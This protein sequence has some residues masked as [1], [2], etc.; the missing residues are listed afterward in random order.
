VY[1][2]LGEYRFHLR[3]SGRPGGIFARR[4]LKSE[5]E[6][7]RCAEELKKRGIEVNVHKWHPY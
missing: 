2:T 7:K 6:V 1:A 4:V 3:W 5:E